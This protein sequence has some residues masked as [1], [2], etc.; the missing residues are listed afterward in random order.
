MAR[1]PLSRCHRKPTPALCS[2]PSRNRPARPDVKKNPAS[3]YARI[4]HAHL[5]RIIAIEAGSGSLDCCLLQGPDQRGC[6]GRILVAEGPIAIQF[7]R[8]ER[9]F[10]RVAAGK[11]FRIGH[12]DTHTPMA[13]HG[14][15][16]PPLPV[17]EGQWGPLTV[18]YQKVWSAK[19]GFVKGKS[20]F[21]G[22]VAPTR[23]KPPQRLQ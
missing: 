4:P 11:L 15:P 21:I 18:S 2:G 12:V 19:G 3:P 7:F 14:R 10:K 9:S 5:K 6:P 13:A 22:C 8:S 17:A 20:V 1:S 16:E 23:V